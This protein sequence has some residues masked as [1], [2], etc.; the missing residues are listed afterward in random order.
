[1]IRRACLVFL[2]LLTF[3]PVYPLGVAVMSNEWNDAAGHLA[4]ILVAATDL[5]LLWGWSVEPEG[6]HTLK[7]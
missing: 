6:H 4:L 5:C 3:A 7:R 1:M 2:T